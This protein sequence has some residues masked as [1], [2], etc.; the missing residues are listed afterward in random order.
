QANAVSLICEAKTQSNPKKTVGILTMVGKGVRVLATPTS[1]LRKILSCVHANLYHDLCKA[2][3]SVRNPCHL[4]STLLAMSSLLPSYSLCTFQCIQLALKHRQNKNQQQRIIVFAGSLQFSFEMIGKCLMWVVGA[5][6]IIAGL[7]MVIL[8]KSEESKYLS[9]NEPIYS[10]SEK[11][12][13]ES[14]FIR[15]LLGNKLQS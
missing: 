7:Y 15:P 9:E 5:A 2:C 6:L 1:E 13:M 8:G 3:N 10:V 12:D 14:T 11:N 4:P